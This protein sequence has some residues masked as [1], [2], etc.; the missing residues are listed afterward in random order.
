MQ[1]FDSQWKQSRSTALG[2][3]ENHLDPNRPSLNSLL[4]SSSHLPYKCQLCHAAIKK[5]RDLVRIDC[6]CSEPYYHYFCLPPLPIHHCRICLR[7]SL[8]LRGIRA[9]WDQYTYQEW[10]TFLDSDE[11]LWYEL[12]L[13]FLRDWTHGPAE[14][15][16]IVATTHL[17]VPFWSHLHRIPRHLGDSEI[18]TMAERLEESLH[19]WPIRDIEYMVPRIDA[20]GPYAFPRTLKCSMKNHSEFLKALEVWS[21]G[22]FSQDLNWEGIYLEGRLIWNLLWNGSGLSGGSSRP[23]NLIVHILGNTEKEQLDR[24]TNLINAIQKSLARP[25]GRICRLESK[26]GEN[27]KLTIFVQ[28]WAQTLEIWVHEQIDMQDL[29]GYSRQ[30][31]PR[32]GITNSDSCS[33]AGD[34][35]EAVPFPW[36]G[37]MIANGN[38]IWTNIHWLDCVITRSVPIE[39]IGKNDLL[40]K[41]DVTHVLEM[42][43]IAEIE[44]KPAR[45]NTNSGAQGKGQQEPGGLEDLEKEIEALDLSDLS[46]L[47]ISHSSDFPKSQQ[48]QLDHIP[49]IKYI[50]FNLSSKHWGHF[51]REPDQQLLK[52]ILSTIKK[53][54]PK[55]DLGLADPYL[56]PGSGLRGLRGFRR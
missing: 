23:G 22:I 45:C 25:G 2:L 18:Q 43:F 56:P 16:R 11:S 24:L 39:L 33:D 13:S 14:I 34:A 21:T 44:K 49:Q 12:R 48:P 4:K 10:K 28:G 8:P 27:G 35:A 32:E 46:M 52:E 7:K 31:R 26:Q 5:V 51:G 53:Q 19:M 40:G 17:V 37:G 9:V 30:C 20:Q 38:G 50:S 47:S 3:I 6:V 42:G 15:P 36:D 41:S 1:S 29:L 54:R 55:I